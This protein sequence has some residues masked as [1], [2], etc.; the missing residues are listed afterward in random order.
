MGILMAQQ[1]QMRFTQ[2]LIAINAAAAL[3]LLGFSGTWTAALASASLLLLLLYGFGPDIA[4][5]IASRQPQPSSSMGGGL[6]RR[7]SVGAVRGGLE[8]SLSRLS[9]QAGVQPAS[10]VCCRAYSLKR[11]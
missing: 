10:R 6:L 3:L 8:P 4:S 7:S 5:R 1:D 11:E 2:L 9:R